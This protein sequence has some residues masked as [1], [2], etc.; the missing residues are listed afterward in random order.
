MV[1]RADGRVVANFGGTSS[2]AQLHL[3]GAETRL[4]VATQEI[5]ESPDR[6]PRSGLS[7]T[8]SRTGE[9]K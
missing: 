8:V 7:F 4:R 3:C 5:G 2:V 9:R 6:M 1:V